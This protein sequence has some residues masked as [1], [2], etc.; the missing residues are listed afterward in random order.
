MGIELVAQLLENEGMPGWKELIA[1]VRALKKGPSGDVPRIF[2]MPQT[3]SIRPMEHR[4][5][6]S[7]GVM[8]RS[9]RLSEEE[10]DEPDRKE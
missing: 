10:G 3:D 4:A 9:A 5:D 2:G 8:P 6:R 1:R 7:F